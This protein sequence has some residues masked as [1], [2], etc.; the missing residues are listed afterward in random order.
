MLFPSTWI[1]KWS[2][3][4]KINKPQSE[5]ECKAVEAVNHQ[6]DELQLSY[7]D[8]ITFAAIVASGFGFTN[9]GFSLAL[10]ANVVSIG[11]A[12]KST[13]TLS[14]KVAT[15]GILGLGFL[16][17]VSL[18]LQTCRT[19]AV[20]LSGIKT[21]WKYR[22]IE[23]A[24]PIRN[25]VILSTNALGSTKWL[26]DYIFEWYRP[27]SHT[28]LASDHEPIVPNY[29]FK[30]QAANDVNFQD[31]D[32]ATEVFNFLRANHNQTNVDF[33]RHDLSGF[34]RAGTCSAMA[35]D[36]VA[37]T[38][39]E[40]MKVI[41]PNTFLDCIKNTE[42]YY[43][44][45]TMEFAS[46]QSAYNTITLIGDTAGKSV[47]VLSTQK[48]QALACYHN[49]TLNPVTAVLR[50]KEEIIPAIKELPNGSYIFRYLWPKENHKLEGH[51][52]TMGFVKRDVNSIFYDNKRG[53]RIVG[54]SLIAEFKD[55]LEE[56]SSSPMQRIYRA[57]CPSEGC[58]NL[59]T[60]L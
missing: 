34:D 53:A 35:L 31:I 8:Y 60:N 57:K 6:K 46:I 33:R 38:N 18:V 2:Q 50:S 47:E 43:S 49:M 58:V 23:T 4:P 5:T 11:I 54:Q 51:G 29:A 1:S 30:R 44:S 40:C 32:K 26:S 45:T 19:W 12:L 15:V 14:Q 25:A 42:T 13:K 39:N 27:V 36:F 55:A 16:P 17:R 59:A 9:V 21:A 48:I 37:R 24:R 28:N 7:V 41:D 56:W 20:C 3:N 22:N 10:S 52:H